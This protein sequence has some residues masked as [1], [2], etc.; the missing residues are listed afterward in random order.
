MIKCVHVFRNYNTNLFK[1][2]TK[3]AEF[4]AKPK[5]K[6]TPLW[7]G[8]CNKNNQ[9]CFNASGLLFEVLSRFQISRL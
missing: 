6:N 3:S 7:L 5:S 2:D 1:F 8:K 9:A 4:A